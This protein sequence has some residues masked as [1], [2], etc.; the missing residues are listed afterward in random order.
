[1]STTGVN[2]YLAQ[3]IVQ[4]KANFSQIIQVEHSF[5]GVKILSAE[6]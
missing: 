3:S 4:K 1:M 6:E 2:L 5:I